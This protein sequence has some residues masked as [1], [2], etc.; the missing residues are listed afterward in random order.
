MLQNYDLEQ[1]ERVSIFKNWLNREGLQL[2]VTLTKEEQNL[3]NTDKSLFE[4]LRKKFKPQ[5][6]EMI[7]SLQF[8]K[9][10]C[11]SNES[12]V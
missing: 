1:T 5:F 11:W 4:T 3:C 6:Y 7:K 12:V 9:L 8:C 2:I 10:V